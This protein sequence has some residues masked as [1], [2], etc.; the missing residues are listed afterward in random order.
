MEKARVQ[1]W[2]VVLSLFINSLQ[3]G[4]ERKKIVLIAKADF[5]YEKTRY[6]QKD[7]VSARRDVGRASR[8]GHVEL[9]ASCRP[10]S[11]AAHAACHVTSQASAH[12]GLLL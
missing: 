9:S 2:E 3:N 12:T 8:E 4:K 7:R 5:T 6:L 10:P 11:R 1:E